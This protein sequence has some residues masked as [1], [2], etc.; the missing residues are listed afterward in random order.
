M[1]FALQPEQTTL[2]AEEAERKR[3]LQLKKMAEDEL[4]LQQKLQEQM[5]LVEEKD[6]S[7]Q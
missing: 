1:F 5:R 7:P 3:R 2:T 4:K 6:K